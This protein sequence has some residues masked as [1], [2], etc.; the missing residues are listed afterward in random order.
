[1]FI[2]IDIHGVSTVNAAQRSPVDRSS[3][4][5]NVIKVQISPHG[6]ISVAELESMIG[7]GDIFLVKVHLPLEG[8][9]PGT[10]LSLPSNKIFENTALF[11]NNKQQ[12]IVG[13]CK[14]GAQWERMPLRY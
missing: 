4:P 12:K 6:M 10:D 8:N 1:L 13:Y 7:K 2:K 9:I 11:S 5:K 14:V 3:I